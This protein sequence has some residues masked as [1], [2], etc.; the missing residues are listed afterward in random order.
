MDQG[1]ERDGM[2][3]EKSNSARALT[4][5]EL[6]KGGGGGGGGILHLYITLLTSLSL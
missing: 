6:K 5:N 4:E 3:K 1:K 2:E